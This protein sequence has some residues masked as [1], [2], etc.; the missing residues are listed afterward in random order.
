MADTTPTTTLLNPYCTVAQVQ[1]EIRNEDA[2]ITTQIE[3]AINSA[4]RYI[5]SYKGRD[6]HQ[7]DYTSTDLI[8]DRLDACNFGEYLFLPYRPI[9]SIASV[10]LTGVPMIADTDYVVKDHALISLIGS[11][12]IGYP[13]IDVVRVR[14]KFGYAQTKSSDVPVG[15]PDTINRAAIL[16]ASALSGHNM[17]EVI[18]V[19]GTKETIYDKTIPKTAIELLGP[20]K[21]FL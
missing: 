15:L 17:K 12:A 5:D 3:A 11:W 20:R 18:S 2:A 9:I 13:P 6:F 10:T 19:T 14:G 16:I 7:H 4:S 21:A 1:A 8:I